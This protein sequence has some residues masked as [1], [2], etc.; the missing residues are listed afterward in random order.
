M[1]AAALSLAGIPLLVAA[2][3]GATIDYKS[4]LE[5]CHDAVCTS[6]SHLEGTLGHLTWR[7]ITI[8]YK[9]RAMVARGDMGAGTSTSSDSKNSDWVLTGHVQIFVPQGQL[10]ADRATAQIVNDR[11]TLLTA[12]GSPAEFERSLDGPAPTNPGNAAQSA[13][14]HARG[15]AH[16]IVFDVERS[17]LEFKG[18]AFVTGGCYEVSSDHISYDVG[19]ERI[20]ADP[21]DG[22]SVRS[23]LRRNTP[24]C[25]PG[26]DKP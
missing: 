14:E 26:G 4:A 10:R 13:I 22:S 7:D 12:N 25:G 3:E 18:E 24:G 5:N 17:Q 19:N 16:E 23:I 20:E 11:V 21:R 2:E 15:H 9:A 8:V 1:M 6:G